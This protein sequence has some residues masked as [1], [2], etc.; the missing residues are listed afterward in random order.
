M[1]KGEG[2]GTYCSGVGGGVALPL[3]AMGFYLNALCALVLAR[4][5]WL[6]PLI[7]VV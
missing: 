3:S 4:F 7:D 6:F 5:Y 1:L 2:Q